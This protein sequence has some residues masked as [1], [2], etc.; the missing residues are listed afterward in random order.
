MRNIPLFA[1]ELGVASLV[2]EQ[3]KY[4]KMAYIRIQS[5]SSLKEFLQECVGFCRAAGAEKIFATGEQIAE[6]YDESVSVIRMMRLREGMERGTS[7]LV[8]ILPADIEDFRGI[9]NSAM[10]NIPNASGMSIQSANEILQQGS[11]Y[12]VYQEDERIGLGIAEEEWIHGIVSLKKGMGMTIMQALNTVLCG[13]EIHVELNDSNIAAKTL[14]ERMGFTTY[15]VVS[16]WY[17]IF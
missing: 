12:F 5:S 9:Y 16:K 11:G 7:K 6:L 14:Y 8:S 2:L 15:E 1:T 3:I 17:K 13:E 4:N 10:R